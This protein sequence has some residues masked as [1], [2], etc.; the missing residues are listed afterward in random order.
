MLWRR[1]IMG[2]CLAPREQR[3]VEQPAAFNMVERKEPE[4]VKFTDGASIEGVLVN[5][6][7]I[8]V[9]TPPKP[10]IRYTIADLEDAKLRC[11]LGS[12]QIDTKLRRG[13]IGHVIGV[14]YEGEDRSVSRNGNAMKRFRVFVSEKPHKAAAQGNQIADGTFITDDDIGF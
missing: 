5:I 11:F 2:T 10:A 13:D 8:D 4:F 1:Q 3:T 6:E 7:R 12:Y 9:G 14:R